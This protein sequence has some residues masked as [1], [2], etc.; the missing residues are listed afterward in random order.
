MSFLNFSPKYSYIEKQNL[1]LILNYFKWKTQE[2]LKLNYKEHLLRKI[3]EISLKCRIC[4]KNI[5]GPIFKE[6]SQ[7]CFEKAKNNSE[8]LKLRKNFNDFSNLFQDIKMFL[9]TNTK[10]EL[11][12]FNF[13]KKY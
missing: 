6:H 2:W 3:A 12:K 11:F 13:N 8:S 10:K 7:L 4:G 1:I 9:L 5:P